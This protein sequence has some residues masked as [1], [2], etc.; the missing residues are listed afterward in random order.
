MS[1]PSPTTRRVR[2]KPNHE[3][4]MISYADL[5]TLLLAL[6]VVLFAS[7]TQNKVK[8]QQ[9]ARSL[10]EAFHG[11]NPTV[12]ALQGAEQGI[13][14]HQPSPVPKPVEHPAPHVPHLKTVAT[15]TAPP[16]PYQPPRRNT[17][18]VVEHPARPA[19]MVRPIVTAMPPPIPEPRLSYEV[20]QRLAAEA[21]ALEQVKKQLESLLQPLT[22]AHQVTIEATPLTLTI[23]LDAAV[24]FDTGKAS[25]LPEAAR[26]LTSV[27]ASLKTLPQPFSIHLDGYT[28]DQPIHTDAFPSNWS[29][30]VERAVSVVQ[31]F[32]D[33]GIDGTRLAAEGFG[34]Y[35][36]VVPNDSAAG[37][38]KNRRVVIVIRAPDVPNP[39]AKTP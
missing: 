29:L 16:S 33:Q 14:Q 32:A 25:L 30:S 8:L 11:E 1:Q 27:A 28:D 5:L 20:S 17:E 38:A 37:R 24:L 10:V 35:A 39:D 6:F 7:S 36:P 34:Q 15:R 22:S 23:S 21:L 3:R 31:L 19:P 9:E 12:I 18:E 4:W 2:K 26:L 13:L